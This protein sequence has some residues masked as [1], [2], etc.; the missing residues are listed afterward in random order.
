MK[1]NK[2]WVVALLLLGLSGCTIFPGAKLVTSDKDRVRNLSDEDLSDQV[3]VERITVDVLKHVKE[4]M[5]ANPQ[6][7]PALQ[8]KIDHYEYRIGKG[9]V[10]NITVWDHPELTIPAGQYRSS[11][12][13][14]NWVNNDGNIFYPYIGEVA[15]EGK[16]LE[17]VRSI[18]T[19]RLA[20]YIAKPQ[21]D[22]NVA[23]FRAHKVYVTGQ[24]NKPGG[25]P[26]T[27]VPLTLL[28]A[29][30]QVDGFNEKADWNRITLHRNGKDEI[31]SLQ[32]LLLNGVLTENRLLQENDI[33][34]VASIEDRMVYVMGSVTKAGT[35]PIGRN[36][37]N[38][39]QAISDA[40]GLNENQADAT[41]VF[42]VRRLPKG[43]NKLA[44]VYQLDLS[45]A[46]AMVLGVEFPLQANDVVYV[47]TAP[48]SR[49][50]RIVNQIFPTIYTIDVLDRINNR[51]P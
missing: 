37:M 25:I 15:V 13:T 26:L 35:L 42:V 40:G 33:V 1:N 46:T 2:I 39:T 9:D 12:E 3:D 45:D 11:S 23:A 17:E 43:E 47:T 36:G 14:G 16:T 50:A 48:I 51:Q 19:K 44:R 27:N 6:A 5:A 20:K 29:I 24:V 28:D 41:G 34:H 7:N 49:W 31:I 32:S 18:I 30:N 4:Q 8:K 10:L 38:L 22:V 21:V